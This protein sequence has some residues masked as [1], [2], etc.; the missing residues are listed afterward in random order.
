M[1]DITKKRTKA[2]LIDG[3][4]AGLVSVGVET[5]LKKKI[6]SEAFHALVTPTAVMWGLEYAQMRSGGQTYGYKKMGLKLEDE[7]GTE[8]TCSQIIKRMAYRDTLSTLDYLKS[9]EKFEGAD[10]SVLPHDRIAGTVVR[11]VQGN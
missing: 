4:I 2:V 8:L 9:R 6:K 7:D 3:V 1:H 10:G 11:E 5:L